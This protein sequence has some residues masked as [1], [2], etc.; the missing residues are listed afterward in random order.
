MDIHWK[1]CR[2]YLGF[3]RYTPS[4]KNTLHIWCIDYCSLSTSKS[5]YHTQYLIQH[6][7]V[8]IATL[9]RTKQNGEW[10]KNKGRW[11]WN[12]NL[13]KR[14]EWY[15]SN[16]VTMSST[17]SPTSSGPTNAG[18]QNSSTAQRS[19]RS[20]LFFRIIPAWQVGEIEFQCRLARFVISKRLEFWCLLAVNQNG[21]WNT[22]W[23]IRRKKRCA[24][25]RWGVPDVECRVSKGSADVDGGGRNVIEGSKAGPRWADRGWGAP[26]QQSS[27]SY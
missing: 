15:Q 21:V 22:I 26:I 27:H 16:K 3:S 12:N 17:K 9:R 5:Y 1:N 4:N 24:T 6:C 10:F 7:I 20:S 2:R 18:T 13:T 23:W 19:W 11:N 25:S 8:C 14:S